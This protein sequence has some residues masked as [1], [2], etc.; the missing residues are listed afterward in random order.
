M[1]ADWG[2]T[3]HL[4][5][6]REGPSV[7]YWVLWF[8]FLSFPIPYMVTEANVLYLCKVPITAGR[9]QIPVNCLLVDVE[10]HAEWEWRL[11]GDIKAR[12][13]K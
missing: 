1:D 13:A 10:L 11:H 9:L 2:A 7:V 12:V 5:S 4:L 3:V 8:F 6:L